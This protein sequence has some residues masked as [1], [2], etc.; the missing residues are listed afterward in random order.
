MTDWEAHYLALYLFDDL[1]SKDAVYDSTSSNTQLHY[2]PGIRT[3][4]TS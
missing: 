3:N 1:Y 4:K 2:N